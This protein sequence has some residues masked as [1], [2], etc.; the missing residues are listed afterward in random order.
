MVHLQDL[1]VPIGAEPARRFLDDAQQHIDA[2]AHIGRPDDRDV[3][4]RL[5]DRVA[6]LRRQAGGA[7]HH[8]LAEPGGECGMLGGSGGRGEFEHHVA[9]ADQLVDR[10]ADRDADPPD[11]GQ[12]A[13]VLVDIAAAGRLAAAGDGAALGGGD[14]GDQHSS[15]PAAAADDAHLGLGHALPPILPGPGRLP[16]ARKKTSAAG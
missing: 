6:L 12:L 8:R 3:A 16:I 10:L 1:D 4:R 13:D 9:V 7:D 15:H 14:L 11:P 5:A 2:E